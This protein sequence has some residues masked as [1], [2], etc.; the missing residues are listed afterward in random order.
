MEKKDII[1]ELAITGNLRKQLDGFDCLSRGKVDVLLAFLHGIL[2][3]LKRNRLFL[4]ERIIDKK[5]LEFFLLHAIGRIDAELDE[6]TIVLEEFE[7]LLLIFILEL[8]ESVDNLLFDV[9]G[10]LL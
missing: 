4:I 2:V 5:I 10:N 9:A 7:I 1:A 3:F 8:L 6:I